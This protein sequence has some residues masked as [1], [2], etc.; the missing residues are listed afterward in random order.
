MW[1][2]AWW[3]TR[4]RVVISGLLLVASLLIEV[5]V[6]KEG[7]GPGTGYD[8]FLKYAKL[9]AVLAPLV[10]VTLAGSGLNSQTHWG[11]T[12]GMHPSTVFLLSMPISR[13]R[14]LFTRA[15]TGAI[16]TALYILLSLGL[17]S[18]MLPMLGRQGVE[19][20][21]F[22]SAIAFISLGSFAAFGFATFLATFLDE[23]MAGGGAI[24][25]I[26]GGLG[27]GALLDWSNVHFHPMSWLI[28]EMFIRTGKVV[29]PLVLLMFAAGAACLVASAVIV[30][31]KEY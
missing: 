6:V 9:A 16:F 14:A 10:A 8:W 17:F 26:C 4:S 28:G 27:A 30:E 23:Q 7:T 11:L 1:R 20:S 12:Q 13:R 22:L 15:A 25:F 31:K 3:E 24:G 19:W 5:F 29:W 2:K 21:Q 18:L